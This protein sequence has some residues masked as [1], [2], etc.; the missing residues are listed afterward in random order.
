[1]TN[2]GSIAANL[3][4]GSRSEPFAEALF[5]SFGTA[6]RA[7]HEEDHGFD[8][9]CTVTERIG[10][11]AWPKISYTVQIK[12][13]ADPWQF[14]SLE[15]VR[16]LVQHPLPLLLCVFD[17]ATLRVRLYHT[18]PR[19]LLWAY[20]TLP[21]ALELVPGEGSEGR[22]IEWGNGTT[23]SLSAPILDRTLVELC[24]HTVHQVLVEHGE[25]QSRSDPNGLAP[26]QNAGHLPDQRDRHEGVGVA[27]RRSRGWHGW[28]SRKPRKDA[29]LARQCLQPTWGSPGDGTGDSPAPVLI[30]RPRS[31]R[32]SR[33]IRRTG[34]RQPHAR[35]RL[36]C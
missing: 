32:P 8:L 5:R 24:D 7:P 15:S 2:V 10:L 29:A 23:F 16:W 33:P 22:C 6:F 17:K 30:S 34:N 28:R 18:F 25:R 27:G 11:R 19:F 21:E 4:E 35:A 13:D 20:G 31:W 36:R 1:M 3:H 26:V 9:Y 14:A 12:S